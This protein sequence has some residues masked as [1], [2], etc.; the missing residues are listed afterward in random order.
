MDAALTQLRKEGFP[1]YDEDVIRLSSFGHGH[2]NMLGRYSFAMPTVEGDVNAS[3]L[4]IH[5]IP[6]DVNKEQF[7]QI[8]H[9]LNSAL[10]T[11]V[12]IREVITAP[13]KGTI[14]LTFGNMNFG[15]FKNDS[16]NDSDEEQRSLKM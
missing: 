4:C 11:G 14:S 12:E 5:N 15:N 8:T 13:V 16:K 10:T 9:H 1:V 6:K 3:S 7:G 2:I